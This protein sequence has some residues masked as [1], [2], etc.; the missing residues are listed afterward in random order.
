M[1]SPQPDLLTLQHLL[2]ERYEEVTRE[3]EMISQSIRERTSSLQKTAPRGRRIESAEPT[4]DSNELHET[5]PAPR[6]VDFSGTESMNVRLLSSAAGSTSDGGITPKNTAAGQRELRERLESTNLLCPSA[7]K[8]EK[9][10]PKTTPE[11]IDQFITIPDSV[12]GV[13]R[14]KV[15]LQSP[16]SSSTRTDGSATMDHVS[17]VQR[18]ETSIP[19]LSDMNLSNIL[20]A[21]MGHEQTKY[22]PAKASVISSA[23]E[24]SAREGSDCS[25]AEPRSNDVKAK[26]AREPSKDEPA[27]SKKNKTFEKAEITAKRAERNRPLIKPDRYDGKTSWPS[28]LKHFE[29]CSE[30]NEWSEKDKLQYLAVLLTGSAQ[31]VLSTMPKDA[32][33]DYQ[34]LVKALQA[35]FD[36]LGR[37]E[38]YRA[39]LR[40]RRQKP[41]ENLVEMAE[42]IRRLVE[43]V[44]VDL[45]AESK[46]HMGRDHFLDALTD[47]DIRIRVIQMRTTTL[48]GAVAAA[49]ELEALQK[50]EKERRTVD[51]KKVNV[52]QATTAETIQA[53]YPSAEPAGLQQQIMN[54]SE[55]L[56]ELQKQLN[57]RKPG[58][59]RRSDGRGPQCYNC[60]EYG[61]I[62]PNCPLLAISDGSTPAPVNV[63]KSRP[64]EKQ[65]NC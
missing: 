30:L 53:I 35:R 46:D 21:G 33:G 5:G 49:V 19:E 56:K 3:I 27:L 10:C 44:Y 55:Q 54:I 50:A 16:E 51:L 41:A 52:R 6:Q 24:K 15:T 2:E 29:L 62:K 58:G 26:I 13:R 65:E 22:E 31:Q 23:P 47:G 63:Q 39:Q 60:K 12:E 61:H 34:K 43:K 59:G 1:A 17:S 11:T 42:E 25:P 7:V 14:Y 36:P 18:K 64:I 32:T 9:N 8:K 20:S 4:R 37:Q 38:L 57:R 28:Y 48:D 40:N 45:P